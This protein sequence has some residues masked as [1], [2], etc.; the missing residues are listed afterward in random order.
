MTEL[1]PICHKDLH[2]YVPRDNWAITEDVVI[3]VPFR[4]FVPRL[5]DI[6]TVCFQVNGQPRGTRAMEVVNYLLSLA[7][8]L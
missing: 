8:Q 2:E 7:G 6:C 5:G 3:I 1:P 4:Y